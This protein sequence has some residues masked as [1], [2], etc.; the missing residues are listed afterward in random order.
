MDLNFKGLL[1]INQELLDL[2]FESLLD[3]QLVS[4]LMRDY[5]VN[6]KEQ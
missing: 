6:S 2:S 5:S 1:L 4:S 3:I